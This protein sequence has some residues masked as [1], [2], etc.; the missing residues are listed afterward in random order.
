V[1]LDREWKLLL[2]QWQRPALIGFEPA[3][4]GALDAVAEFSVHPD[5]ALAAPIAMQGVGRLGIADETFVPQAAIVVA[6]RPAHARIPGNRGR[7]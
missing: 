4:Q 7:A 5:Q 1:G 2:A 3:S 6:E